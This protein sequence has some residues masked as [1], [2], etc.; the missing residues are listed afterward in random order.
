MAKKLAIKTYM[1]GLTNG[2][3]FKIKADNVWEKE[4]KIMFEMNGLK[5]GTFYSQNIA[6]WVEIF[7]TKEE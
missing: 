7:D 5:I 6:G 4:N 3:F 1:I 2:N